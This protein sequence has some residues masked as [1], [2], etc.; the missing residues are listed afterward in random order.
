MLGVLIVTKG[1]SDV[2]GVDL[3]LE[4]FNSASIFEEMALHGDAQIC[5]S[6][7]ITQI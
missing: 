1:Q 7:R 2:V 4:K 6:N 5:F 3:Y